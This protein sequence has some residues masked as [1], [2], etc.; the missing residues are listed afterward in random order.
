MNSETC[1]HIV[2]SCGA[3]GGTVVARTVHIDVRHSR[4]G[5]GAKVAREVAPVATSEDGAFDNEAA[6]TRVVDVF[7]DSSMVGGV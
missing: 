5:G 4:Y 3:V 7:I 2:G 1:L 6:L